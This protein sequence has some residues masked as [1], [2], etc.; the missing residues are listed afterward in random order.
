MVQILDRSPQLD[1]FTRNLPRR[2][3]CSNNPNPDGLVIR[4]IKTALEKK[5]IQ[6]NPPSKIGWLVFD[7]DRAFSTPEDEW[8]IAAQPNIIVRNPASQRVHIFYGIAVPVCV[9]EAAHMAPQR[10]LGAIY[11][12]YRHALGA[13]RSFAQ[14]ICKNPLS[15]FWKCE[16]GRENLYELSELSEYVDLTAATERIRKTPKRYRSGVERNC[17]LFDS[18]RGWAYR[19]LRD[20]KDLG[21][22]VWMQRVLEQ[23]ERFNTFN[24]PLPISEVKSIAKSVGKWTWQNYTGHSGRC[25]TAADLAADGLT[26]ETFSLLQSSLGTLGNEK[27]WGDNDK[28]I[29]DAMRL[30]S[31]GVRQKEIAARLNVNQGTVS[32][33]LKSK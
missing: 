31:I 9:T 25:T 33:W 30:A 3:Y 5:Y 27:R 20:Y 19:W 18:L 15:S 11:E 6:Y 26:P 4:P 2:P 8:I 12:G 7:I 23:C 24:K 17:S 16:V 32:R 14:L 10:L 22:D 1:L 28:K 21:R 13:D 29:A